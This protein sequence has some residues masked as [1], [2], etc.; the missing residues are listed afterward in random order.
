MANGGIMDELTI[1]LNVHYPL[2]LN[3]FNDIE[4]KI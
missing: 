4:K 2:I 1:K 3:N